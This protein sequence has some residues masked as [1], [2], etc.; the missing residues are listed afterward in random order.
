MPSLDH[1]NTSINAGRGHSTPQVEMVTTESAAA[2]AGCDVEVRE[3]EEHESDDNC[4]PHQQYA[5][6]LPT[7]KGGEKN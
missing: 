4:L 2:P 6:L 1:L 3:T 5:A 7:S